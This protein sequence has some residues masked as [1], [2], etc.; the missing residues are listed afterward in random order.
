MRL[1]QFYIV[2][3]CKEQL[4]NA[5]QESKDILVKNLLPVAF[6]ISGHQGQCCS[7]L[8]QDSKSTQRV[9]S[10]V[11]EDFNKKH[12]CNII[13]QGHP[14]NSLDPNLTENIGGLKK[15]V[16]DMGRC[17]TSY[18]FIEAMGEDIGSIPPSMLKNYVK[19]MYNRL[20]ACQNTNWQRTRY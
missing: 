2:L 7:V 15:R 12:G 13:I 14:P 6:Q 10:E 5:M 9:A 8:L 16:V 20:L 1:L 17:Q 11:W 3:H 4:K 18:E 19:C